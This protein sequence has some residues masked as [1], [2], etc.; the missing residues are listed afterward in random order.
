MKWIDTG[1]EFG[2]LGLFIVSQILQY[3]DRKMD[4]I[5]KEDNIDDGT[6]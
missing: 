6:E 4:D 1:V 3:L 2:I 5:K